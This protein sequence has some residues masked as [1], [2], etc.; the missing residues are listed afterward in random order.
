MEKL[1]TKIKYLEDAECS[2]VK[3]NNELLK[4]YGVTGR[5]MQAKFCGAWACRLVFQTVMKF[6]QR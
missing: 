1:V 3:V 6:L 4:K 2:T 5:S